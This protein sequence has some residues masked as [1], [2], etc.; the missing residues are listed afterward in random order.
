MSFLSKV[1]FPKDLKKLSL[2]ELKIFND[3]LRTHTIETVSKTGKLH[4]S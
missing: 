3:E 1:N 4:P 2:E